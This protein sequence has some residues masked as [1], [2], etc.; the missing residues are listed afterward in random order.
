MLLIN[1]Y[2]S[3]THDV[4]LLNEKKKMQTDND[5]KRRPAY[6]EQDK[7]KPPKIIDL[8]HSLIYF[9]KPSVSLSL[10]GSMLSLVLP[11]FLLVHFSSV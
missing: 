2:F 4:N 9:R 7:N 5:Q 11:V 8:T 6:N 3:F 1:L 10:F